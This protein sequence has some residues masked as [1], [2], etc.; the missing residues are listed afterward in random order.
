[1]RYFIMMP[2]PKTKKQETAVYEARMDAIHK[3]KAEGHSVA[4]TVFEGDWWSEDKLKDRGVLNTDMHYFAKMIEEM[5]KC[6][7]VYV[8]SDLQ[9]LGLTSSEIELLLNIA[10]QFAMRIWQE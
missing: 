5:S 10:T 8:R 2:V 7:G 9:D 4:Y 1:M 3:V 6:D